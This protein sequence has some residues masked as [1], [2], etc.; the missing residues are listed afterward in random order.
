M[1]Q[2]LTLVA[3]VITEEA[4]RIASDSNHANTHRWACLIEKKTNKLG[5]SENSRFVASRFILAHFC[6]VFDM[7]VKQENLKSLRDEVVL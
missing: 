3:Q 7:K 6:F 5:E 4:P 1:W 2:Q